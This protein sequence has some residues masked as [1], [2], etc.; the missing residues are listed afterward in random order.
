MDLGK[1]LQEGKNPEEF[2][3]KGYQRWKDSF[4]GNAKAFEDMLRP[5]AEWRRTIDSQNKRLA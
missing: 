4:G 3:N 1:V 5:Q 2:Y